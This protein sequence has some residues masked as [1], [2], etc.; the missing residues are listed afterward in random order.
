MDQEERVAINNIMRDKFARNNAELDDEIIL[1]AQ[2]DSKN[3]D[4]PQAE[5][6]EMILPLQNDSTMEVE[7]DFINKEEEV[8]IES[9]KESRTSTSYICNICKR[10]FSWRNS[11]IKHI[12]KFHPSS[13]DHLEITVQ[14]GLN[15]KKRKVGPF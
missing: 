12:S 4:D 1:E 5:K 13:G 14:S 8:F 2:I 11:L 9:E 10:T 3:E 7:T 6:D 15:Q